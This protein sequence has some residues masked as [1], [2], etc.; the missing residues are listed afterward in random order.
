MLVGI[1]LLKNSTA[2]S[3]HTQ[4]LLKNTNKLL[5]LQ[6]S[7]VDLNGYILLNEVFGQSVCYFAGEVEVA[8]QNHS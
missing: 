2:L 4:P 8:N 3:V 6:R 5:S 7:E 1:K